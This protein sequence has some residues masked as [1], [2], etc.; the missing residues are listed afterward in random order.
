MVKIKGQFAR[1][2]DRVNYEMMANTIHVL[3]KDQ[4][5]LRVRCEELKRQN[6]GNSFGM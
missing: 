5:T 6:T 2:E 3:E 1:E 4:D